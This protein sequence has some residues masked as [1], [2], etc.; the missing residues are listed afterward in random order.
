MYNFTWRA[1]ARTP[2]FIGALRKTIRRTGSR[3]PTWIN[4]DRLINRTGSGQRDRRMP[5]RVLRNAFHTESKR[6]RFP[7]H[8]APLARVKYSMK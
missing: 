3:V 5:D 2:N 7:I 4:V 6:S 1:C 8:G